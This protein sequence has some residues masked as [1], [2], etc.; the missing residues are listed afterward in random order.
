[1]AWILIEIASQI[2]LQSNCWPLPTITRKGVVGREGR[3]N[4]VT[5]CCWIKLWVLPPSTRSTT[6]WPEM[7]ATK[8][9]VS[10]ASWPVREFR[11]SWAGYGSWVMGGSGI[12]SRLGSKLAIRSGSSGSSSSASKRN[13]LEAQWWPL[14]YFLLQLKQSPR[15]QW[16]AISSEVSRL[17]GGGRFGIGEEEGIGGDYRGEGG[18]RVRWGLGWRGPGFVK[19]GGRGQGGGGDGRWSKSFSSWRR[20]KLVAWVKVRS[21]WACTSWRIFGV[22]S[23]TK[24]LRRNKGRTPITRLAKS[25][26][27]D[28]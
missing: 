15:S 11:L 19:E 4:W 10:G 3:P 2:E 20:A 21:W 18:S 9:S 23:E 14:W 22:R 24:Q 6:S 1:M 27:S 16:E 7:V 28:W 17:K 12:G 13:T 26:N 25:S 5:N 8:Q